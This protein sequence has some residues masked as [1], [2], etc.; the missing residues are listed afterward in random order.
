MVD[1]TNDLELS[2]PYVADSNSDDV[3][4]ISRDLLL[5]VGIAV[6]FLILGMMIGALF[7]TAIVVT[8]ADVVAD[9]LVNALPEGGGG[10]AAAAG[11]PAAPQPTP[12]PARIDNVS[13]DDD[14]FLGAEDAPV[15]IVE[16]SDFRCPFCQRYHLETLPQIREVYG[17]Q[18]RI[19]FRDFPVVGG[20]R[21]AEAA[22]CAYEQDAFWEYHDE[23][24][25]DPQAFSSIADYAS[26]ADDLGLDTEEFTVCLEEGRYRSEIANDARDATNYGVTGTPTFFIN[27]VRLVG[28]QPFE[29]FAEIIEAELE[30]SGGR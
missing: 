10:G 8:N 30:N 11:Q 26:L 1:E 4:V 18:V 13:A 12:P 2:P 25:A 20:Q 7:G 15:T 22:N 28:A 3:L 19:V 14:P 21:A 29:A 6:T 27:G 17:D 16:F 24:F 5:N 9:T 23:L